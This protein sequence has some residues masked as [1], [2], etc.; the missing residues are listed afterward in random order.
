MPSHFRSLILTGVIGLQSINHAASKI[1]FAITNYVNTEGNYIALS[2][3]VD[4]PMATGEER[5]TITRTGG[6]ANASDFSP[7]NAV[8]PIQ[9]RR[10]QELAWVDLK[11]DGL[12]EEDET[13]Q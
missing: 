12:L 7:S 13:I 9:A 2:L 5:V 6:S 11:E 10:T 8:I 4:P 3:P 1:E